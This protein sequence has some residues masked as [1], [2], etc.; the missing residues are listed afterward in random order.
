MAFL[1]GLAIVFIIEKLF[2]GKIRNLKTSEAPFA[3]KLFD[4][5]APISLCCDLGEVIAFVILDMG[6]VTKRI[7][8]FYEAVEGVVGVGF[9][10]L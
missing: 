10:R 6:C 3:I 5:A 8:S 7:G 9:C 1:S 4:G 2:K